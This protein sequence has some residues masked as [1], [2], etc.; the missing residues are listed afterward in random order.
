[1]VIIQ[2]CIWWERTTFR[3]LA[4]DKKEMAFDLSL[5]TYIFYVLMHGLIDFTFNEWGYS[6]LHCVRAVPLFPQDPAPRLEFS[7]AETEIDCDN[8]ILVLLKRDKNEALKP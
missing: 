8:I 2:Y 6:K 1:M 7:T 3:F 4:I 5:R